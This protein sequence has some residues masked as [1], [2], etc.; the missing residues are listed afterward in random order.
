MLF[1]R[2]ERPTILERARIALWPRQSWSRSFRYFGKRV[3]R[4]TGSPHAIALGFAAG[5]LMSFTPFVGLH[6]ILGALTAFL[7]GGNLVAS[8]IGTIVGNPLTFPF[9]WWSTYV[10][11]N[12]MLNHHPHAAD[13]DTLAANIIDLPFREI[14]PI[15]EPMVVGA[16]PLGAAAA[17]L[18]YFTVFLIV[19]AYRRARLRRLAARRHARLASLAGE[20][21]G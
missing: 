6:I 19:R 4:L 17:V 12:R 15:L 5:V 8:A 1:R 3:V 20:A 14:L 2:R 11:G 7:I 18:S 16:L 10:V 13:I 9:I 21:N